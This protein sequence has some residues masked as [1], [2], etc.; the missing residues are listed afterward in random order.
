MFKISN[1]LLLALVFSGCYSAKKVDNALPVRSVLSQR[2]WQTPDISLSKYDK[3]IVRSVYSK[4]MNDSFISGNA[5]IHTCVGDENEN[6]ADFAKYVEKAFLEA[7]KKSRQFKLVDKVQ[8]KT[9]LIELSL[10]KV[11][12][13]ISVLEIV[14]ELSDLTPIGFVIAPHKIT[15]SSREG[16][17]THISVAIEGRIVDAVTGK[18][19]AMF[20]DRLNEWTTFFN[21]RD[22]YPNDEHRHFA[23]NWSND[24]IRI[25]EV[26]SAKNGLNISMNSNIGFVNY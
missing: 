13:E 6:V 26:P 4:K 5:N 15:S 11:P 24:F 23:E 14:A 12:Q 3:I 1:L 21:L 22:F 19:I 16:I 8:P 25:L 7:V 9:M 2:V 10:V 17:G 18:S 20:D